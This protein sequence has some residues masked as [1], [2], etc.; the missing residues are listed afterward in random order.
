MNRGVCIIALSLLLVSGCFPQPE[1]I[2]ENQYLQA[3]GYD[4]EDGEI[5]ATAVTTVFRPAQEMLSD[6]ETFTVSRENL[7][8]FQN[9]LQAEAS[10]SMEVSRVRVLLFN[11]DLATQEGIFD[12]L[13]TVQRNPMI[14]QDMEI[15]TTQASTQD[16][17][18]GDYPFQQ[19]VYRYLLD[20]IEHNQEQYL[21][22][23][24]LHDFMYQYYADGADPYV[25]RI[26]QQEGRVVITGISLFQGDTYID[27]LDI[28]DTRIFQY[29]VTDTDEGTFNIDLDDDQNVVIQRISSKPNWTVTQTDDEIH[30]SV[31]V[32]MEGGLREVTNV[33]V[34]TPEN[35]Q[36]LE[37]IAARKL[38]S[39]M[40]ETIQFFQENEIDPIGISERV[41][42]NIR[43][44]DIKRWK[45]ETYPDVDVDVNVDFTIED[46]GAVE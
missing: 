32:K 11:E 35:I 29:L 45:D 43:G 22:P 44:L 6:N 17:L 37:D 34:S 28:E 36:Q 30:V 41:G 9:Q 1:Y 10:R 40:G 31:E 38:E 4:D 14:E 20:L 5:Q 13:D 27:H 3:I 33:D 42:Q 8:D 18:D 16:I 46:T 7:K 2:E 24:S 39:Q 12:L 26:D 25:T 21:P 15:A 23:S 19:S